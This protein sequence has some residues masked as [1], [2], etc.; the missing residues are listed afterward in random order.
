MSD[1]MTLIIEAMC[2]PFPT[3]GPIFLPYRTRITRKSYPFGRLARLT[4]TSRAQ[5]I[6]LTKVLGV[7]HIFCVIGFSMGGQQVCNL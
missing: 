5:Y 2:S 3:M 6:I 7:Q 1:S 4:P